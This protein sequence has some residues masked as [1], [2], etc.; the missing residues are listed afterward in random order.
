ME[1]Q[2]Y[3]II[4]LSNYIISYY[5]QNNIDVDHTLLQKLLYYLKV[6][7]L[8]EQQSPFLV[9][10]IVQKWQTGP[11]FPELY[12]RLRVYGNANITNTITDFIYKND[13][14]I[15]SGLNPFSDVA[16]IEYD[17]S[18]IDNISKTYINEFLSKMAKYQKIDLISLSTNESIWEP[19]NN[20]ISTYLDSEIIEYF[21]NTNSFLPWSANTNILD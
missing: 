4:M 14:H 21:K 10:G 11:I 19:P 18:Q 5:K 12:D 8:I 16:I 17:D 1:K 20:F 9:N 15:T 6:K 7:C 2:K 3:D 13:A